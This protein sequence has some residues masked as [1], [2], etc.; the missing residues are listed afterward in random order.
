MARVLVCQW[1]ANSADLVKFRPN[2]T[3]EEG[4]LESNSTNVFR[5]SH[6]LR[7]TPMNSARTHS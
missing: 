4:A 2:R 7:Q 6:G 3:D 1:C 5:A